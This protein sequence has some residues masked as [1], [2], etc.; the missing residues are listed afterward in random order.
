MKIIRVGLK[1]PD[2]EEMISECP[3][4]EC[5]FTFG[6]H[7]AQRCS[8]NGGGSIFFAHCPQCGNGGC[9]F[10]TGY[11]SGPKERDDECN[12]RVSERN[13]RLRAL[14]PKPSV[15]KTD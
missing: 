10:D 1:T 9:T 4:C 7:E 11:T 8:N 15:D 5:V 14:I 2:K 12:R 13:A 3:N 6:E